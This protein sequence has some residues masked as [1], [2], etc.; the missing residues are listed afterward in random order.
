M[1]LSSPSAE[2][3]IHW[4][5]SRLFKSRYL[6]GE[7]ITY[8]LLHFYIFLLYRIKLFTLN[9]IVYGCFSRLSVKTSSLARVFFIGSRSSQNKREHMRPILL[10]QKTSVKNL[11]PLV[12]SDALKIEPNSIVFY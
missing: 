10:C 6:R 9:C 7:Y 5:R 2:S 8:T 3:K 12:T 1:L 11:L 4:L